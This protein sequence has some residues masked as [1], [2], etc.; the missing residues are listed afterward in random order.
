MNSSQNTSAPFWEQSESR[1]LG[2]RQDGRILNI[3]YSATYLVRAF[4]GEVVPQDP[5]DEPT[6]V[7]LERIRAKRKKT[8]RVEKTGR[9]KIRVKEREK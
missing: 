3:K 9:E 8:G 2:K 4:G 1:R 6:S 7:L 5:K